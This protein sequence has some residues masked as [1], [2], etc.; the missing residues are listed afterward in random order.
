M[1]SGTPSRSLSHLAFQY[2]DGSYR[3]LP[4]TALSPSDFEKL[5]S[6][7][8]PREIANERIQAAPGNTGDTSI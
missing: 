7:G 2:R 6:R 5:A 1:D 3:N 8:I 4:G